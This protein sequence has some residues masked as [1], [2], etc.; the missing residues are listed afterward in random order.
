MKYSKGFINLGIVALIG[1]IAL[2]TYVFTKPQA[3]IIP[4]ESNFDSQVRDLIDV[5]V[6]RVLSEQGNLGGDNVLPAGLTTYNLSGS[7]V[8][9]SATSITLSSL[10]IPQTG[11]ELVDSD[12]SDTFYLTLEPGN[13]TRQEFVSCTTVTQNASTATLSGCSRGLSPITPFSASTT[14]QFAHAGGS[15]VIF[16]NSPQFYNRFAAKD[17]DE[18][19]TGVYTFTST[20]APKYNTNYTASGNEFVSYTQLNGVV[21]GDV[22]TSTHSALG[23]V[24]LATESEASAGTASSSSGGPLVLLSRYTTSTNY[25]SQ[26][27]IV[28]TQSDGT[29]KQNLMGLTEAFNFT[30]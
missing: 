10:T 5:Y 3:S 15:Q 25:F 6:K 30:N 17:N 19:I 9:G 11:Q 29:I 8:S 26:F 21:V 28:G 22:G 14:L 18:T 23:L 2:G 16:S 20:S 7:G 1:L 24:E 27:H 13:R 4:F 12:F